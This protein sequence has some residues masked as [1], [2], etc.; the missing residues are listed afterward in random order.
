MAYDIGVRPLEEEVERLREALKTAAQA[1][2]E[3]STEMDAAGLQRASSYAHQ[4]HHI[5]WAAASSRKAN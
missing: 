3:A 4:Q 5:A 1:L 2:A